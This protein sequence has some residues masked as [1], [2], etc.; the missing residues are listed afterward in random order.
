M[1]RFP[2][3]GFTLCVLA[4]PSCGGSSS[5]AAPA[6]VA[7]SVQTVT[8][9]GLPSELTVGTVVPLRALAT[10]TDRLSEDVTS[11]ARWSSRSLTCVVTTAGVVTALEV[12]S[13]SVSA[14]Y[15]G[16]SGDA[17]VSVAPSRTFTISGVVREKYVVREPAI[18][19]ATVTLTTGAQAGR[20]V[21]A[22]ALGR[23]VF[24]GVP[25]EPVRVRAD[26]TGFEPATEEASAERPTFD[27][28]L[29]PPTESIRWNSTTDVPGVIPFRVTHRG[30]ANLTV[31]SEVSECGTYE[32][33]GAYV[34]RP[35]GPQEFLV[36]GSPCRPGVETTRTVVLDPG[37]YR[38]TAFMMFQDSRPRKARIELT[39][40][41]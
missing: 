1:T 5:P 39:Y 22:D 38:L 2:I 26:A 18:A 11:A 4:A 20:R 29:V 35:A 33:F 3:A 25:I 9:S 40:P 19:L 34:M 14:A 36:A 13:C 37:E 21:T 41:K 27:F 6:A 17:N 10:Y 30:P 8:I 24:E 31:W 23:Y 16:A 32:T 7:R 28:F 12:G 15:G